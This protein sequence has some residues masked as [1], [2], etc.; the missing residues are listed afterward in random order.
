MWVVSPCVVVVGFSLTY[1]KDS[2]RRGLLAV[3]L[4]ICCGGLYP[5]SGWACDII[6]VGSVRGFGT[7]LTVVNGGGVF[8]G[9]GVLDGF[10]NAG[11]IVNI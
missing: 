8:H 5:S 4:Y 3:N 7:C 6:E 9:V 1:R 11:E 10:E 2:Q